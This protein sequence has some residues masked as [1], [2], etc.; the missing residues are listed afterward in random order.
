MTSCLKANK[1]AEMTLSRQPFYKVKKEV[2]DIMGNS[3]DTSA[4][5]DGLQVVYRNK[6]IEKTKGISLYKNDELINNIHAVESARKQIKEGV[7]PAYAMKNLLLKI[8]G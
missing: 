4:F 8:G 6:L 3:E 5:L 7:S 2:D 1:V